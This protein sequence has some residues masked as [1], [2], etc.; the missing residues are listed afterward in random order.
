MNWEWN[1]KSILIIAATV[2]LF[3]GTN[4]GQYYA[5]WKPKQADM[6]AEYE[7][8]LTDMKV[9]YEG[10]LASLQEQINRI[11]P[12]VNIWTIR[13][14]GQ[15][16]YP[17]K[18]IQ[19]EDL[20]QRKIPES[21][22]VPSLILEPDTVVGKYYRVSLEAGTPLS[23]DLVMEQPVDDTTREYDV[24]AGIMPIGL[25][26]GDYVDFRIVYPLG[27]DYI[28]LPHKRIQAINEKSVKL[29]LNE[30]EIHFYQA[31][32]IDYFL[33]KDKGA[34][35]Y[36]TK[37]LEPGIQ[38]P[39]SQFYAIPKNIEA[40][41]LADPNIAK[42]PNDQINDPIR[43]M[44]EIGNSIVS[45]EV[46]GKI[47]SG[48]GAILGAIEGGAAKAAEREKALQEAQESTAPVV[49][50]TPASSQSVDTVPVNETFTIEEG[51]VE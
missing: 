48:R 3:V 21:L 32:L 14:G 20:E 16:L 10:E 5:I 15:S 50:S 23:M 37:Y 9:E 19:Y 27:E 43:S 17:G 18:E 49:E 26:V 40:I 25:R 13:D 12:L 24:V 29:L 31:A 46:G 45:D 51:V 28:V 39:A 4:A 38:Q 34:A 33:S 7:G 44:I 6:K 35:L 1:W 47:N 2:L 11:G 41:M 36:M 8:K 42:S 22:L 30:T